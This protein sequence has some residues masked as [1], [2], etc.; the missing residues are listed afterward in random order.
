MLE[1]IR[2]VAARE[3]NPAVF[4]PFPRGV[5][6][7]I[8]WLWLLLVAP[9][10]LRAQFAYTVNNN[11]IVITGYPEGGS[12]SVVV[13]DWINGLPVTEIGSTAFAFR[14]SLTSIAIGTNVARI[15]ANA[16]QGCVSLAAVTMDEG[17]ATLGDDAFYACRNLTSIR[18]PDS[19]GVLGHRVFWE[20]SR[21]TN[22]VLGRGLG[23]IGA[24]VFY[25]CPNLQS[26]SVRAP[27]PIFSSVDGELLSSLNGRVYLKP[28]AVLVRC[29]EGKVGS[30]RIPDGVQMIGSAAFLNCAQLTSVTIPGSITNFG[31]NTLPVTSY[32]L[33]RLNELYFEGDAPAITSPFGFDTR[34]TVY[35]LPGTTGWAGLPYPAKL[36]PFNQRIESA[37]ASLGVKAGS[38]GFTVVGASGP[39]FVVEAATDLAR[40][41][42]T[43]I[44]PSPLVGSSV[45]VTDPQWTNSARR[46]YRV[47][48]P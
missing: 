27:N 20:C 34:G 7:A 2:Q 21:L 44:G 33:S 42:W 15:G 10:G 45:Y 22:V 6:I 1:N 25:S 30:Y 48:M 13:P 17:V 28:G 26:I 3:S 9:L 23:A 14:T 8:V 32:H 40:P 38:F 18:L 29:P 4:G 19:L 12:A 46:F 43:R 37:P 11:Q 39:S 41:D 16:F 31:P 5:A 36:V 47:R 35:Y 24:N